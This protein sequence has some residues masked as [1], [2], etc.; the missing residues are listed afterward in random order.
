[1]GPSPSILSALRPVAEDET[2]EGAFL[3]IGTPPALEVAWRG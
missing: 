2:I 1:M 3:D